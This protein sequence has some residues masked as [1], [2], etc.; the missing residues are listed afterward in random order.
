MSA[1]K[2]NDMPSDQA[3]TEVP[4]NSVYTSNLPGILDHFGISLAV[5][6][7]QAG[8]VIVVRKDGSGINTH[9]RSFNKPMGMAVDGQRLTVG[10]K[11]TVWYYRNMP[12][13][14]PK[15]EPKGRHD[16]A[17]I[18]REV[19]VTGDIDIHEL[20]WG[21]DGLWIVNTRFCCLCTFEPDNS[22]NPVWRPHFVSA[23][24][25]EDRC[26]LNG[27]AADQHLVRAAR[28]SH[29]GRAGCAPGTGPGRGFCG[30]AAARLRGD[31]QL[32]RG[33]AGRGQAGGGNR[34]FRAGS[35]HGPRP[36]RGLQ[37]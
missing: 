12:A 10:G 31:D 28:R 22:F 37:R 25:P 18:P 15:L 19:H 4:L 20:A 9:F 36:G 17:Y 5:S 35:G 7:Y 1:Q 6:T 23:L 2:T 8:K 30:C 3:A 32:G 33:A 34:T 21:R 29:E 11:N 16:A 27:M 26:H 24:A 13:L 14:A